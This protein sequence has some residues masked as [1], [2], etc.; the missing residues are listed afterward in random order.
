MVQVGGAGPWTFGA[1]AGAPAGTAGGRV[2]AA[3]ARRLEAEQE[4]WFLWL[5]VLF[6]SGIALYFA[7][8]AEPPTLVALMPVVAALALHFAG[9]RSGLGGVITAALLAASLGAATAKLRTES[10]RAP[11]LESQTRALDVT[12]YLELIEPRVGKGQ[13]LT[14]RVMA[15]EKHAAHARPVRVRVVTRAENKALKPGHAVR[16]KATLNSPPGPSLPGDFDFARSAWFK[17]LGAVGY[18]DT[19]A[20]ID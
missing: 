8:R 16:L 12:G 20:E 4:R 15:L 2:V 19:P 1:R 17:R 18:A 7:L 13:R 3:I 5:P 14:I 6:G 10:V 9:P 11:V